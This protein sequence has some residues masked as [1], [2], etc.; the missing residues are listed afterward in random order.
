MNDYIFIT[1]ATSGIGKAISVT[2]SANNNLVLCG[3]S[4]SKL[5]SVLND[6]ENTSNHRIFIS[7]FLDID[8][9]RTGM[10]HWLNETKIQ[11]KAFIHCAGVTY[12]SSLKNQSFEQI[13]AMFNTN[14]IAASELLSVLTQKKFAAQLQNII[15]ISSA[16][17]KIG[18][19]GNAIYST[20]K[21]AIDGFTR[22]LARELAPKIR[23]NAVLPGIVETEMSLA[24]IKTPEIVN[25]YPL[26]TG[27]VDDIVNIVTFLLSNNSKWITGQNI[28]V[29]GGR[30]LY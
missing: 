17:S 10:E 6:C 11:I 18:E 25:K 13:N 20:T 24:Y 30:I 1:G 2:L 14:F 3:R 21:G 4:N 29:D 27:K 19:K 23:V 26:G 12:P 9:V 8:G 16:A 28:V 7:D 15:F 22:T 5:L